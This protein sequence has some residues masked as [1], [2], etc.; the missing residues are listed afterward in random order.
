MTNIAVHLSK[1]VPDN[2]AFADERSWAHEIIK[3]FI[4]QCKPWLELEVQSLQLIHISSPVQPGAACEPATANLIT[5]VI[6]DIAHGT[7]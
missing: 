3:H 7:N 6:A 2:Q 4:N 5:A 1:E